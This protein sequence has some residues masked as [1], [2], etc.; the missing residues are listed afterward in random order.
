MKRSMKKILASMLAIALIS[1]CSVTAFAADTTDTGTGS[2]NGTVTINGSIR[3]LTISVTHPLTAAYAI[4]PNTG[5]NGTFI[6]P[7]ISVKNNTKVPINV[8]VNSLTAASGGTITFTDVLP[9]AKTWASL[10]A[11]DSKKYIALGILVKN[12]TGW[13]TGYTTTTM[14]AASGTPTMF[15]TLPSAASGTFT[16]NA[17]YGLAFD[18]AYT[19]NH[20][21]VFM[22]QLN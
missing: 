17:S 14:Y 4:D 7:D 15:G 2:V 18:G 20:S 1:V 19:A 11:A 8:T 12:S 13:N 22:F 3:A 5:E 10:N 21:L 9:A 16:L 6:A